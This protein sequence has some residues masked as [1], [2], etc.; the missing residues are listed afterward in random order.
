MLFVSSQFKPFFLKTKY[1]FYLILKILNSTKKV[2]NF[3]K[4]SEFFDNL[5]F[6]HFLKNN[7]LKLFTKL[8]R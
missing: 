2:K 6:N 4:F 3:K 8:F 7:K 5:K 1:T